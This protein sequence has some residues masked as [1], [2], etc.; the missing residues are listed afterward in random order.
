[1]NLEAILESRP[2]THPDEQGKQAPFQLDPALLRL[3]DERVDESSRTLET[4]A[5]LSTLLFAAKGCEHTCVV[6]FSSEIERIREWC[7]DAGASIDRVTF[8]Q[9]LS[10]DLLPTLDPEPL[11]LVLID[12]GHGFPTPFI[13]WY[14]AGRRLRIGGT[15]IVDDIH[16]W[17]GRVLAEFLGESEHWEA[18]K[19]V[20]MRAAAF[21][22][23]A[24]DDPLDDW[25]KQ[26]FVARRSYAS[27]ARGLV[28][29]GVKAAHL[30][31]E[32]RLTEL[33]RQLARR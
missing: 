16:L 1:V 11:D 20:P 4:G 7:A 27:G 24:E 18:L 21:R 32:G 33:A 9:R 30:A 8:H 26:P 2:V 6:P 29:R 19:L 3:I 17:T 10:E 5:G 14:Y 25:P 22:R 13:D 28:R 15:L 31:R 12:G 23:V